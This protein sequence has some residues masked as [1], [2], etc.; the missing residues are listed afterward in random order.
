[1]L[2]MYKLL[3]DI[4]KRFE[5][6]QSLNQRIL[7]SYEHALGWKGESLAAPKHLNH[8]R[9]RRHIYLKK[10]HYDHHRHHTCFSIVNIVY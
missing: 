9:V 6:A 4:L 2:G 10:H 1:M 8:H 5:R 3:F 7:N